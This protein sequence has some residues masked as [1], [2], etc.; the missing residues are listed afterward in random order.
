MFI[1]GAF[2][3]TA[4]VLTIVTSGA[5]APALIA[6]LGYCGIG[7]GLLGT[8][9]RIG[10]DMHEKKAKESLNGLKNCIKEDNEASVSLRKKLTKLLD[11]AE[12][13]EQDLDFKAKLKWRIW[14]SGADSPSTTAQSGIDALIEKTD[15]ILPFL[16]NAFESSSSIQELVKQLVTASCGQGAI[17]TTKMFQNGVWAKRTKFGDNAANAA[18]IYQ[19]GMESGPNVAETIIKHS[20]KVGVGVGTVNP[21][22]NAGASAAMNAA[23]AATTFADD[24][25]MASAKL[26]S[27]AVTNL[28]INSG[29]KMMAEVAITGGKAGIQTT[30]ETVAK[31]AGGNMAGEAAA[32]GTRIGS[33]TVVENFARLLELWPL[34]SVRSSYSGT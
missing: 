26:G 5:A 21:G 27:T 29:G 14:I 6:G 25:A 4:G 11:Y 18:N 33:K 16:V 30:A 13:K 17:I 12:K 22:A 19:S 7:A 32:F 34:D 24:V 9:L 23:K 10:G 8:G 1:G 3:I 31:V 20:D 2:T 15:S 28:G